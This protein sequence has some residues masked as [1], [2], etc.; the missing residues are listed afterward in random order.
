MYDGDGS[1]DTYVYDP[2]TETYDD[3]GGSGYDPGGYDSGADVGVYDP[4]M[5]TV[6]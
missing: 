6:G 3:L 2:G 1:G 4:G 5:D